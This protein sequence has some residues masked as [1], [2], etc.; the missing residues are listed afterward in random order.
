VRDC[1]ERYARGLAL[2]RAGH[3]AEAAE[4]L[5]EAAARH[6]DDGPTQAL[7]ARSRAHRDAPPADFE[8]VVNLEK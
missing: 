6:P 7:L 2:W 5:A 4:L 3:F 8:G 1:I